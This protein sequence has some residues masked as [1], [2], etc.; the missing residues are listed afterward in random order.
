MATKPA[1]LLD[2]TIDEVSAVDRGANPHAAIVLM[3]RQGEAK[4]ATKWVQKSDGVMWNSE[5]SWST[6]V[7]EI[8]C[9]LRQKFGSM[10]EPGESWLYVQNVYDTTVVFCQGG[11]MW[12]ADYT[13]TVAGGEVTV[14]VGDRVA[15]SLVYQDSPTPE[16][17]AMDKSAE[18]VDTATFE[19]IK[20]Q[21]DAN[22]AELVELRKA[23][24]TVT[25]ALE[26]QKSENER[27]A[28]AADEAAKAARVEKDLR[29]LGE[30]K[31]VAKRRIPALSGSDDEKAKLIKSLHDNLPTEEAE[32]VMKM[33]EAGNTAIASHFSPVGVSGAAGASDAYGKFQAMAKT[34]ASEK[35]ISFSKAMAAVASENPDLYE[36]YQAERRA[37]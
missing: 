36:Q 22:A 25:A 3:K 8:C 32:S 13:A 21:A 17:G 31:D 30:Y 9:A 23:A 15:V 19:A 2:L 7:D 6:I 1:K 11:D 18:T 12:R 28:K 14:T 16:G 27:L 33:L 24:A 10:G 5:M 20:K 37:Q 34:R 26:S 29:L 4:Q 35:G